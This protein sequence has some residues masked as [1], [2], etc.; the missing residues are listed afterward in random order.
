MKWNLF[1]TFVEFHPRTFFWTEDE[2]MYEQFNEECLLSGSKHETVPSS[3]NI[4][5]IYDLLTYLL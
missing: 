1:P 3:L 4:T 5:S 2:N